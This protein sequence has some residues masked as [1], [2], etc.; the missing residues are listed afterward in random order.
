MPGAHRHVVPVE[1]RRKVVRMNPFEVEGQDAEPALPGADQPQTGDPRQPV[2]T[3]AGQRLLVFEDVGAPQPLDEIERGAEP[4]RAGNV[5]G[6]GLEAVRRL[7]KHGLLKGDVEDHLAAALPWRHRRQQFVA[8]P[9]HADPGRPIS[10]V[11]GEGVEVAA[12]RLHVDLEA[13]RRLTAVDQHLGPHARWASSTMVSTGTSAPV[14]LARWVMATSRVRGDSS[15][16][17]A[18]RSSPPV[19]SIGATTRRKPRRSRSNC[20]GTMFE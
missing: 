16:A 18:A 10:L 15:A 4:D 8:P 5:R 1:H 12:Q 17:K 6:A 14:A 20:H 2:D 19:A 9:Q 11:A 3:V 13:R 7:L